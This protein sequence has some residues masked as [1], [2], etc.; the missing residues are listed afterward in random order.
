MSLYKLFSLIA[1]GIFA[2]V[3]LIF[4]FFPDAAL[5]FFNRISGYFGLPEAPLEGVG[6]YLAL[7]VAYMY[8]VTLLAI[9]MYRNPV[10]HIYPFLLTHAKLASSILSLFLFFIYRPYLIFLANFVVDGLI[11]LAALYFYLKIRKTGLSGN[12]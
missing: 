12:A 7:A 11:G 6:F 2:V 10:Q 4:L 3:G 1:A 8:L 9:L 5:I